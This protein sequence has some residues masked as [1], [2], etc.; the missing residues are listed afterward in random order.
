MKKNIINCNADPFVPEGWT[1]EKHEKGGQLEWNPANV[2]LYPLCAQKSGRTGG[3]ELLEELTG[4]PVLNANVLDYL[5]AHQW[6]YNIPKVEEWR[7]ERGGEKII[8]F[9]GTIYRDSDGHPCVRSLYYGGGDGRWITSY[10]KI[11]GKFFDN[12]DFAAL[13]KN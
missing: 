11:N 4:K 1:V 9:W 2:E 7:T 6:S 8:F 12:G 3:K 5:Y 13:R 10:R